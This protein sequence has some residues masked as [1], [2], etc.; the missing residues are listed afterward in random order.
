MI[1]SMVKKVAY[2]PLINRSQDFGILNIFRIDLTI[3]ITSN[4]L[5]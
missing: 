5:R 1:T 3:I 4:L 2:Q